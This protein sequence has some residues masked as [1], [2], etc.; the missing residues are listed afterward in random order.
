[1]DFD[2]RFGGIQRLIGK[3]KF[4]RLRSSHVCVVGIGG[5]GSWSAEALARS[6]I[7][8]ITL[9]DYDDICESNINRQ[10]HSL[11]GVIGRQKIDVMKQRLLQISPL[12]EV[13]LLHERFDSDTAE[14]VLRTQFSAVIDATDQLQQKCLLIAECKERSI[15]VV[16]AGGSAG[17]LDPTQIRID[18]LAFSQGDRLLQKTRK[19]TSGRFW[20][21]KKR[22]VRVWGALCVF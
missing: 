22:E 13:N 18:D 10:V 3:L 1:L 6:G 17:K 21:S 8:H 9:V 4:E 11:D 5:V 19:K 14:T 15:P 12:I 7:G 2:F 20:F 16:V